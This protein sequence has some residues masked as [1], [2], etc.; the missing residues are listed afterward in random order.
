MEKKTTVYLKLG[1]HTV[2]RA[3]MT[4]LELQEWG[5]VNERELSVAELDAAAAMLSVKDYQCNP[6]FDI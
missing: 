3:E 1:S 2:V 5:D 6:P 4:H